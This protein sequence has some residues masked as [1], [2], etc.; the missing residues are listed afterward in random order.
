VADPQ[1]RLDVDDP[2]NLGDDRPSP[3][4][5]RLLGWGVGVIAAEIAGVAAADVLG[6]VLGLLLIVVWGL[7]A[8]PWRD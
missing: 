2:T 1:L 3:G 8:K 5:V 6:G 7:W 4:L